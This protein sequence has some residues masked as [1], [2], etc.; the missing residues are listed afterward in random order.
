[1]NLFAGRNRDADNRTATWTQRGRG[2][3]IK[4]GDQDGHIYTTVSDINSGKLL[5]STES[6]AQCSTMTQRAGW[7]GGCERS[8][9]GRGY[10][11]TRS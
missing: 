11:L 7:G 3:W 6:S 2:R 8:P 4:P 5:C 10:M 9:G 1:M